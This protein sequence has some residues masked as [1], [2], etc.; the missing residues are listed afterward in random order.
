MMT[1]G[2]LETLD[3]LQSTGPLNMSRLYALSAPT[4]DNMRVFARVWS[5]IDVERRR[6]IITNLAEIA[7]ASFHVDFRRIFRHALEDPDPTVRATAVDGLWEDES[8]DLIER[9]CFMLEHDLSAD[10]RASAAQA[11]G[12]YVLQAELDELDLEPAEHIR[13]I[14][15]DVFYDEPEDIEVRRR[16]LESIAYYDH[17]ETREMIRTAY[18]EPPHEMQVSAIFAMGRSTDPYWNDIV[19]MELDNPSP[20]IRFE[21]ARAGGELRIKR[22]VP[23]LLDLLLDLDR[24]IQEAA[25]WALGQIGG[26]RA[27][28]ALEILV[29]GDDPGLADAAEEAFGELLLMDGEIGLPL[30]DFDLSENEEIGL[31]ELDE[32]DDLEDVENLDDL[33]DLADLDNWLPNQE[34]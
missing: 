15:Q 18:E 16:A 23:A 3:H 14:L 17:A 31:D 8:H 6:P 24:E 4:R 21:A 33:I 10:V 32:L 25:I 11:L 28:E 2:F 19:L 9:F 29:Q 27:R 20:E 7:E 12:K 30:Y 22:A 26:K 5:E 13:V 34:V 1:N